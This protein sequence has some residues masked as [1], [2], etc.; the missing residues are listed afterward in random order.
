MSIGV[1]ASSGGG[2]PV[3]PSALPVV[4]EASNVAVAIGT[5]KYL[6]AWGSA[7]SITGSAN[8]VK[9]PVRIIPAVD[10]SQTFRSVAVAK[11]TTGSFAAAAVSEDGKVY[12]W[13]NGTTDNFLGGQTDVSAPKSIVGTVPNVTF[14][15]SDDEQLKLLVTITA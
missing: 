1:A 14:M 4:A 6:Y 13:G 10:S 2:G 9:E 12:V 3:A 11:R 5:D 15:L 8:E 7:A